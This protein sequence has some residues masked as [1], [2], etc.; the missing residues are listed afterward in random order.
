ML[1]AVSPGSA[2][3][4]PSDAALRRIRIPFVQRA[5]LTHLGRRE[6]LFLVD[7]GLAGAFVER[8]E[9][10]DVGERVALRFCLPGNEIPITVS[11]RVAWWNPAEHTASKTRPSGVGLEFVE[12]SEADRG[13]LRRHLVDHLSG[14]HGLRHFERPWPL[15]G[16]E[17]EGSA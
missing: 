6:E 3:E 1:K 8:E 13:R 14:H 9:P 10:L 11:C 17:G 16:E 2:E 5:G 15:S 7:L 12:F 4:V